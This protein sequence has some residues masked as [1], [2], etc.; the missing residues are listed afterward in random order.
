MAKS[1]SLPFEM[2]LFA[3]TQGSAAAELAVPDI[4]EIE[5][6]IVI[7]TIFL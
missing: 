1:V 6:K 7:L 4:S 3:T 2:P 5:N